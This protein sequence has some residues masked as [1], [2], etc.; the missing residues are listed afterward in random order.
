MLKKRAL[1]KVAK[2]KELIRYI[3][4]RGSELTLKE[5]WG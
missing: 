3:F 2:W 1:G 5:G 4:F